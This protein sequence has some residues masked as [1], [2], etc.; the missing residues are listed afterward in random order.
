MVCAKRGL[1]AGQILDFHDLRA[2]HSDGLVI[3]EALAFRCQDDP[4][5]AVERGRQAQHAQGI[6]RRDAGGR[7]QRHSRRGPGRQET[8]FGARQLGQAAAGR[9]PQL[10][11]DHVV[12]RCAFHRLA[13]GIAHR[14]VAVDRTGRP[15]IDDRLQAELAIDGRVF[16][17]HFCLACRGSGFT[18]CRI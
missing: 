3:G 7:P 6:V 5:F 18:P 15:A 2:D 8:P 12:I 11:H 10:F 14:A 13:H 16:L 4:G 9:L 17:F 1:E